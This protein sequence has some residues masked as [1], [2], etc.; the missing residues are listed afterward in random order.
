MQNAESFAQPKDTRRTPPAFLFVGLVALTVI[1]AIGLLSAMARGSVSAF[2]AV[3]CNVALILGLLFGHRWAYFLVIIFSIAGVSVAFHRSAGHGLLV[4][5]CDSLVLDPVMTCTRYFFPTKT[6][7][8]SVNS[9][10]ATQ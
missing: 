4:L 9:S 6:A 5:L 2:A 1:A 7:D 8:S 10:S 3:G